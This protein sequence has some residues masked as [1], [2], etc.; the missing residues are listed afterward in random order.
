MII[1]IECVD[2]DDFIRLKFNFDI[3][4]FINGTSRIKILAFEFC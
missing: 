1:N 3:N 4:I 2:F